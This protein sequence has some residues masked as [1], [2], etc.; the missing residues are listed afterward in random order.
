MCC[1]CT[2]A[3]LPWRLPCAGHLLLTGCHLLLAL[4]QGPW[5]VAVAVAALAAGSSSD[6]WKWALGFV[7]QLAQLVADGAGQ[8]GE[9]APAAVAAHAAMVLRS[10]ELV[11]AWLQQGRH[12]H[13]C[14]PRGFRLSPLPPLLPTQ[15]LSQRQQ[16]RQSQQPCSSGGSSDG[17]TGTA[18]AAVPQQ[19]AQLK[20]APAAGPPSQPTEPTEPLREGRTPSQPAAHLG[21]QHAAGGS[22]APNAA[23]EHYSQAQP[24]GGADSAASRA[25]DQQGG[26][27]QLTEEQQQK[28]RGKRQRQKLARQQQRAQQSGGQVEGVGARGQQGDMQGAAACPGGSLQQPAACDGGPAALGPIT[29]PAEAH[30]RRTG[31]GSLGE[32]GLQHSRQPAQPAQ[33]A[34]KLL[35]GGAGDRQLAVLAEAAATAAAQ[36]KLESE[37]ES[38]GEGEGEGEGEVMEEGDAT[39]AASPFVQQQMS[40]GGSAAAGANPG[41]MPA[42][43]GGSSSGSGSAASS[44]SAAAAA[45]SAAAGQQGPVQQQQ[46]PPCPPLAR[47]CLA[48]STTLPQAGVPCF[49]VCAGCHVAR[50][51]NMQCQR[52]DWPS[53]RA[54]C[55]QVKQ[56]RCAAEEVLKAQRR[57]ER[58]VK[59]LWRSRNHIFMLILLHQPPNS[60][61]PLC[62]QP[63]QRPSAHSCSPQPIV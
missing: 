26:G 5:E 1:C 53:H 33:P 43:S 22:T 35:T 47:I 38:E 37:S 50:Y 45:A 2:T 42:A 28:R 8:Q 51:C 30:M 4:L 6:H 3:A 61:T 52:H 9:A 63:C 48:C 14:R 13:A 11:Q 49:K 58:R 59:Q 10:F 23:Q 25:R 24:A 12:Q 41:P 18:A 31:H 57:A 46:Q 15:H 34:A 55:Q 17:H 21:Q 20:Q 40:A 27:N 29:G 7:Q 60:G 62:L 44:S 32:A 39:G 36:E 19:G 56:A 16:A 54:M